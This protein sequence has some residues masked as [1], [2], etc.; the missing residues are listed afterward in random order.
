MPSVLGE[1]HGPHA[2]NMPYI[3]FIVYVKE[4]DDE[5]ER[6]WIAMYPRRIYCIENLNWWQCLERDRIYLLNNKKR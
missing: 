2:P 6:C 3:V 1:T 5:K 4:I